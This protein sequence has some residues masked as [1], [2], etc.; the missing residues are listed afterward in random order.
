M[1]SMRLNPSVV[2]C[3][4]KFL[5]YEKLKTLFEKS[6]PKPASSI[7]AVKKESSFFRKEETP[8]AFVP[9]K[10]D[11]PKSFMPEKPP[12]IPVPKN[13]PE[14]A[15][16]F[17]KRNLPLFKPKIPLPK[18]P[19]AKKGKA[20]TL[21]AQLRQEHYTEMRRN[22]VIKKGSTARAVSPDE[23][24]VSLKVISADVSPD[25]PK[26]QTIFL[27]ERKNVVDVSRKKRPT[28]VPLRK[29]DKAT[30]RSLDDLRKIV[31]GWDF[32]GTGELPPAFKRVLRKIPLQFTSVEEYIDLFEPF[33]ILEAWESFKPLRKRPTSA[34]NVSLTF[35]TE[36]HRKFRFSENDVIHLEPETSKPNFTA[37]LGEARSFSVK[38]EETTATIRLFMK[39]RKQHQHLFHAQ[40]RWNVVKLFSLTT[41][42]REYRALISLKDLELKDSIMNPPSRDMD[43]EVNEESVRRVMNSFGLNEPQAMAIAKAKEQSSGF[44]LIQGPPGTGKTKTIVGLVGI[45]LTTMAKTI[46]VP[47]GAV[48]SKK[49]ERLLICAPSN[50]ACDEILKRL[51]SGAKDVKGEVF[52]PK[53]VRLGTPDSDNLV[54]KALKED[55]SYSRL[56]TDNKSAEW[57]ALLENQKSLKKERDGLRKKEAE[58]QDEP[59]EVLAIGKKIREITGKL[60]ETDVKIKDIKSSRSERSANMEKIKSKLRIKFVQDADLVIS[61]LSGA[62]HDLL[63]TKCEVD[64][65]TVIIDEA[66]QAVELSALIPLKYK[67]KKCV[68]VGDPKQL[69]PTILSPTSIRYGYEQSL[70]QRLMTASSDRVA[71]LSIQYRMHPEISSFPSFQFYESRLLDAEKNEQSCT[72]P[73]HKDASFPPYSFYDVEW[74]REQRAQGHSLHNPDE[75]MVCFNLVFSLKD[76]NEWEVITPYKLQ[77]IKLRDKFKRAFGESILKAIDINTVDAFQGQEKDIIIVSTVRAGLG[78]GGEVIT[79]LKITLGRAIGFLKDRRRMNVALTRP[80]VSLCYWAKHIPLQQ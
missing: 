53:I 63:L 74:G 34:K 18:K 58:M 37:L 42:V 14:P 27:D 48:P 49:K 21:M 79:V 45:L 9:K 17:P 43:V 57:D 7:S 40:S 35:P 65:P 33:A 8:S 6:V 78:R 64:F 68:L 54:T 75:V 16:S 28:G 11:P 73:W 39:G 13:V 69:P 59:A 44:V 36:Q 52:A 77:M 26:R 4:V 80:K 71:L 10:P 22:N 19:V 31:L 46:T 2:G 76:W 29:E 62:G 30:F 25:R 47:G 60:K 12:A 51:R 23:E 66:G 70:F 50:A 56:I 5:A 15:I 32:N 72:A 1:F 67:A 24:H 41:T 38:R 3:S 61:T 55:P 20:G